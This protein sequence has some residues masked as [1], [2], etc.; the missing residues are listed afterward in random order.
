M[1]RI[2][3]IYKRILNEWDIGPNVTQDP[4]APTQPNFMTP[5]QQDITVPS[6]PTDPLVP[7]SPPGWDDRF[8]DRETPQKPWKPNPNF[9]GWDQWPPNQPLAPG[10]WPRPF[11][12]PLPRN[13][14]PGWPNNLQW[15]PLPGDPLYDIIYEFY[16]M[17]PNYFNPNASPYNQQGWSNLPFDV[18]LKLLNG[19]LHRIELYLHDPERRP[20]WFEHLGW[21][22]ALFFLL[23]FFDGWEYTILNIFNIINPEAYAES[24][25]EQ[26]IWQFGS[27]YDI[28]QQGL[29]NIDRPQHWTPP[30]FL[31]PGQNIPGRPGY[32]P[33]QPSYGNP[34][35]WYM[36]D[37]G[38]WQF[39]PNP[40]YTPNAMPPWTIDPTTYPPRYSPEF[41]PH[42]SPLDQHWIIPGPG[43]NGY[44]YW[45]PDNGQWTP[46]PRGYEPTDPADVPDPDYPPWPGQ[47]AGGW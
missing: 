24:E 47:P 4:Y 1:K 41:Y 22:D 28:N 2:D 33:T 32:D 17:N 13:P 38:N 5:I 23:D 37:N 44:Y 18:R 40:L 16:N 11:G 3:E 26:F 31:N 14:P 10:M 30:W 20:G 29:E 43:G 46:V 34:S 36:D 39:I 6:A 35:G 45:N 27:P 15:P 8:K 19:M 12:V 9:Q 7:N 25:A 42:W 21:W